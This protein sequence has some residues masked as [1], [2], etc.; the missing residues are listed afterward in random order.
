MHNFTQLSE[1]KSNLIRSRSPKKVVD[2]ASLLQ[3][4]IGISRCS[5]YVI[6]QLLL[7][8][9]LLVSQVF[10][11]FPFR[12][13]VFQASLRRNSAFK[14]FYWTSFDPGTQTCTYSLVSFYEGL[15]FEEKA[16][17]LVKLWV[18]FSSQKMW[19]TN[20]RTQ[21]SK[22]YRKSTD[23]AAETSWCDQQYPTNTE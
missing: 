2:Q 1:N 20:P 3:P 15:Q 11:E 5:I 16:P 7:Q 18:T 19:W 4:K 8:P 21:A 13:F 14:S 22:A 9:L 12:H 10:G 17:N 23:L 6:E